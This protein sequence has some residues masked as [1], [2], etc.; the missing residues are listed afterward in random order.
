MPVTLELPADATVD[1]TAS[2]ELQ[3]IGEGAGAT[4]PVQLSREP[5][6][7]LALCFV[8]PA[9]DKPRRFRLVQA[10]AAHASVFGIEDSEG[11]Y[12]R[13]SEGD[14]PVMTYNYGA[15]EHPDVGENM[16]RSCYVHP[17]YGLDGKII[18]DDFPRDHRHHRGL[19]WTWARVI[20]GGKEHD[21]WALKG[22]EQ[23][24]DRALHQDVGPV[25]ATL[26]VTNR[27]FVG[28]EPIVRERVWMRVFRA[29]DVG[30]VIDVDL[31]LEAIGKTVTIS[32]RPGKGYSGMTLRFAPR[33]DTV[34][35]TPDG[36]L[37][38]DK[39]RVAWPWTDL[40]ARIGGAAEPSG[41]AMFDH[42]ANPKYPNEWLV[43]H[44][45]VLDCCWPSVEL[46]KLKPGEPVRMRY[47]VWVHRGD[48][49]GGKVAA[50]HDAFV[51][52][53]ELAIR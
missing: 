44:Y 31:T 53:T 49:E 46:Y 27:W 26:G 19:F 4:I 7:N 36:K 37:D 21:L 42:P 33:E 30:R 24:F 35:T 45:G 23:Q 12:L 48:F 52:G 25:C 11:K 40:S 41:A 17:I 2:W 6:S 16:W 38:A 3:E 39:L 28:D 22:C 50:A 20:V 47:R 32:G 8:A 34:I 43:R 15:I 51:K 18:S 29:G 1:S 9:G 13:F 14:E 5:S 10:A